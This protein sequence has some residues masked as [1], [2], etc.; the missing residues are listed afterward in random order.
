MCCGVAV[1]F[2]HAGSGDRA[3]A[4]GRAGDGGPLHLHSVDRLF[5]HVC[6]AVA[7]LAGRVEAGAWRR[8]WWGAAAL[9]V[10][11]Y[12]TRRQVECWRDGGTLSRHAIE[13]APDNFMAH[14]AYAGFLLDTGKLAEARAEC[15]AAL[16]L[17]PDYPLAH[18]FLARCLIWKG[19]M[20]RRASNCAG[21]CGWIRRG[22]RRGGGWGR[23]TWRWRV[24]GGGG[25][26]QDLSY[27]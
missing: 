1:V 23:L 14:T 21:R 3:G 2:G 7:D 12:M 6:W 16:R 10:C 9:G 5:Y 26:A 24:A 4:G 25:A 18:Q 20:R 27:I 8:R 22:G 13:V 17:A 15:E 11:L 19:A